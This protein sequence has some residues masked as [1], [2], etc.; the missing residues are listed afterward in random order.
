MKQIFKERTLNILFAIMF[1][2]H[3]GCAQQP[4]PPA[5]PQKDSASTRHFEH[6]LIVVLENQAYVSAIKD[7][8][9]KQLAEEGVEFTNFHGVEHPSYPNYLAMIS[10][11]TCGMHGL[12]GDDQKTFPDDSQH[13]TI[14]DGLDWKNYAESYPGVPGKTPYLG[15]DRP[16]AYARKHVP[17]LSFEKVQK[18]AYKNV[19]SVNTNDPHNAF[20]T[21][22]ENSRKD[23]KDSK[24][25]ALPAYMFYSPNMNDDG[26][27]TNL[28]TASTWLKNFLV[29]WFPPEARAGTLIVVTFDESEPPERKTNHI[30]TVLLGDMVTKGKKIN[31]RYDHFDVLRTIEDNFGLPTLNYGDA[32]AK[33]IKGIWNE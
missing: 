31:E 22:V 20:I 7:P 4:A 3:L 23:P 24:Y 25:K 10:G 26:H 15:D 16:H 2:S 12:L 19:V 18:H 17:F 1:A 9:L 33:V 5:P 21:D 30:Y 32:K 8:Y 28:G 6:V 29:N 27:D 11:S 14:G 13:K